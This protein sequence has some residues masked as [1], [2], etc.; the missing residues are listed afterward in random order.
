M[1]SCKRKNAALAEVIDAAIL[2]DAARG[3]AN[4]W[5]YLM[6]HSVP[7]QTILRVLSNQA[8]RRARR[9]H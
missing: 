3:A 1:N 9:T 6:A 8:A 7:P 5:A 2:I 4:A